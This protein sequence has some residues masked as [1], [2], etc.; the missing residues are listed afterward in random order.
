MHIPDGYLSPAT[1]AVGYVVAVPIAAVAA[2]RV[3]NVVKTRQVPT[4]AMLSAV[5]FLVMMFNIPIP[6]GTT[7]HAVG[8]ALIAVLLGPWA[9]LIAVTVALAFQALLFGDGGVLAFGVNVFNMGV[10]LPFV[11]YG[12]YR[13]LARG[14]V[15]TSWRRVAAA[16]IGG[17]VGLNAAAIC[18]GIELGIQP[19]LFHDASGTPLYS[20]YHLSQTLPAMLLAHLLIAGFAEAAL[21]GGVVAYLQQA[22]IPLLQVNN[23]GVPVDAADN[24]APKPKL[25]PFAVALSV[26]AVL[27]LLTPLGLL[28]PGGAFGEDSPEDLDLGDLGL[29]T[30]PTG[31]AKYAGFWNH[32]VLGDY[33]FSNGSHSN[34]GYLVSAVVGIVVVG[35]AVYLIAFGLRAVGLR[36]S[37]DS[38]TEPARSSAD[39]GS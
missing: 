15:L 36:S 14:S 19:D 38:R 27:V 10:V 26:M 32:T 28:A 9:A 2:Q 25:R 4:L 13:L 5:S 22:N 39:T 8:G 30:V 17:Y 37:I 34:I 35:A 16:A 31:L 20:P 12:I 24:V 29:D 33:G 6:D 23:P 7:A 1:C 18:V 3:K 11:A 21:A